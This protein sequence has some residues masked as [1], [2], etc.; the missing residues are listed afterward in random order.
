[1]G[2]EWHRSGPWC[3]M[4]DERVGIE[5]QSVYGMAANRVLSSFNLQAPFSSRFSGKRHPCRSA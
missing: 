3:Q 5:G 4:S 2:R 1:M